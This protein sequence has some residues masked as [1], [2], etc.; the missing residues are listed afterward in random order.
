[1]DKATSVLLLLLTPASRTA[2]SR[3]YHAKLLAG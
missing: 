3:S 1:M 2:N